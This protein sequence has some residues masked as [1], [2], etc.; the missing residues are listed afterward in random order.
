MDK[1]KEKIYECEIALGRELHF[2]EMV[3][4]LL[5]NFDEIPGVLEAR[6][7]VRDR[8]ENIRGD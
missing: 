5:D 8:F 7:I 3:D 4:L 6:I 2:G 1:Y